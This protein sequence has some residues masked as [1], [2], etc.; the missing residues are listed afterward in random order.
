MIH[1]DSTQNVRGENTNARRYGTLYG[2]KFYLKKTKVLRKVNVFVAIF[3]D[4]KM[5]STDKKMER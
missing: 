2:F 5:M 4:K 3:I 1:L